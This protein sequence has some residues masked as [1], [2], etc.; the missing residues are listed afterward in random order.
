[1]TSKDKLEDPEAYDARVRA[2][3]ETYREAPALDAQGTH[4][5]S[6]DEKTGMQAPERVHA[7]KPVRPGTPGRMEFEYKRHGTLCLIANWNVA[8]GGLLSPSIGATRT[9]EDFAQHIA[10]TI[11]TD[12]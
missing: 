3:C 11:D 6:T 10:R 4:V 7:T 12:P 1:M 9:E 2:V 5:V 8:R